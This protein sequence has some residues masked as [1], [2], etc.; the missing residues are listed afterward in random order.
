MR[1][2]I[3]GLAVALVI[4][5]TCGATARS[6]AA[7]EPAEPLS[8]YARTGLA[9]ADQTEAVFVGFVNARGSST[10]ARFQ[11]GKTKAYGRWFPP[12][13]PEHFYSGYHPSEIDQGV[14]GLSPAT[15]YHFRLVAT[16]EG[17]VTYGRDKTF[18]TLRAEP[19]LKTTH[20]CSSPVNGVGGDPFIAIGGVQA[21]TDTSCMVA[22]KAI[23][24][25]GLR[26]R[27]SPTFHTKHWTCKTQE[28]F[29]EGGGERLKCRRRAKEAFEFAWSP[30]G[31]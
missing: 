24:H 9:E 18:R 22:I 29:S 16:S 17:G 1:T 2:N 20:E 23:L 19:N 21:N 5:G 14:D 27:R 4:L 30:R 28:R 25:G 12:G 13:P 7:N 15:T 10:T 6:A 11:V 3:T 31:G 8:P 26:Y